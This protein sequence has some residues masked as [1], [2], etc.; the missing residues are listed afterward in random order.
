MS[1]TNGPTNPIGGTSGI[2]SAEGATRFNA[3]NERWNNTQQTEHPVRSF[4]DRYAPKLGQ[5]LPQ[6]GSK[7]VARDFPNFIEKG[8]ARDDYYNFK[9]QVTD[10]NG[11]VP[12]IGQ[13]FATDADIGYLRKK[14]DDALEAN[15]V[16]F[17][18]DQMDLS[19]PEKQDYWQ[20]NFPEVFQEKIKIVESQLDL[21]AKLAKLRVL[22]PRTKED[23]MLI[24]SIQHGF[25]AVP[26]GPVFNPNALEVTDFHRGLFNIK[27]WLLSN[28]SAMVD[29]KDPLTLGAHGNYPAVTKQDDFFAKART[30]AGSSGSYINQS[31]TQAHFGKRF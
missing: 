20:K 5:R 9:S 3:N 10:R 1:A 21:Q 26:Q 24:W 6:D 8:D 22:G 11:I 29:I 12:G 13:A 2:P 16:A 25:I 18:L 23:Y 28:D 17:L 4:I 19:S 27:K 15:F 30:S 14:G 31:L 7:G